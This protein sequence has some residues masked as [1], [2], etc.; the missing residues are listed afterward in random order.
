MCECG[1]TGNDD[2]YQL[3]GPNDS[4][5]LITMRGAC[6]NCDG[7]DVVLIEHFKDNNALRDWCCGELPPILPLVQWID[8]QGVQIT[9]GRLKDEFIKKLNNHLV[10]LKSD[11]LADEPGMPLDEIAAEEILDEMYNDTTFRPTVLKTTI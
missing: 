11:D 8:T 9:T 1:C 2:R 4:V 6:V 3:A 7:S 10:G 5:Y